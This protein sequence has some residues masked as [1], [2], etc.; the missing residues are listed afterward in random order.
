MAN[1]STELNTI[2]TARYGAD[3]R[4]AI[5]D[6]IQKMNK[7]MIDGDGGINQYKDLNEIPPNTVTT[8]SNLSGVANVPDGETVGATVLCFYSKDLFSG[9]YAQICINPNGF[10]WRIMWG[11]SSEWQGWHKAQDFLIDDYRK[12][13]RFVNENDYSDLNDLPVNSVVTYSSFDGIANTPEVKRWGGTVL[14]IYGGI[15]QNSGMSQIVFS[16]YNLY[17]RTKWFSDQIWQDWRLIKDEYSAF[18]SFSLFQNFGVIGDSFASGEIYMV[19]SNTG[20]DY[21]DISW[22]QILSRISG[23]TCYNFTKGGLTTR[24]WL[25]DSKGLSLLQSS[26]P[27]QLYILCLGLNDAGKLGEGYLGQLSD[28]ET[29]D[30]SFYGNYGKIVSAVKSKSPNAKIIFSTMAKNF[31]I[32]ETYN[33]AIVE[34]ANHY[35]VPVIKQYDHPFFTSAFY[36]DGMIH[37]HPFSSV[38]SGMAL[39][40]KELI[41]NE[42]RTF[43]SYFYNYTGQV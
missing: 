1:I 22:G 38:Y 12:I 41:E 9:G 26:D 36:N 15:E 3:M 24:S 32:Y 2:A 16:P 37:G 28:I 31:D 23:S 20:Y 8:F 27:L 13:V 14:T 42:M 4:K 21:Y 11:K 29:G 6:S 19:G 43:G 25:T 5:H 30:D 10:W 18:T 33:N 17:W 39:A 7:Y 35:S 34:I 40:I